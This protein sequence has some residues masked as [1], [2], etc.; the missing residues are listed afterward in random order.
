M[1]HGGITFLA[2]E[3]RI[4]LSVLNPI[5]ISLLREKIGIV[6]NKNVK[7]FERNTVNVQ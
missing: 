6:L 2:S 5:E 3:F 4:R 1:D 7:K